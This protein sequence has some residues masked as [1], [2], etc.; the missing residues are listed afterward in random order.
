[1]R[2]PLHAAAI[3]I[4]FTIAGKAAEQQP[5]IAV[6]PAESF[7]G[8]N[9]RVR[10]IGL[11]A[12]QRF[13]VQSPVADALGRR[14]PGEKTATVEPDG[15]LDLSRWAP[16]DAKYPDIKPMCPFWSMRLDPPAAPQRVVAANSVKGVE[17]IVDIVQKAE[18][19]AAMKCI[20]SETSGGRASIEAGFRLDGSAAAFEVVRTR[21]SHTFRQETVSILRNQTFAVFHVHPADSRPEP[22]RQD[23]EVA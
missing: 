8:K 12:G 14:W 20:W 23:R 22:S 2:L 18:V 1:M 5:S 9:V 3:L 10:V 6:E 21:S 16:S 19:I 7:V 15:G 17:V 13:T 4:G 11:T